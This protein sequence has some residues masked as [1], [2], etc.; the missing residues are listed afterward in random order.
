MVYPMRDQ[1]A[2]R[3]CKLLCCEIIP[4]FR[5]P[6][7][8]LS[9]RGANLLLHL[10][11][12]VCALLGTKKLNT[13][14]YHPMCN[15][16]VERFNRMLKNLLKKH[17]ARFV[18]NWDRYLDGVLW[19]YRNAPHESTGEK[20]SFLLFGVDLRTPNSK[21]EAALLPPTP[22]QP[23]TAEDYREEL[24]TNLSSARELACK[25]LCKVQNKSKEWY[26]KHKAVSRPLRV[27]D[28]VLVR[29]PVEESGKNRKLAHPWYGPYRII[30]LRDPD[31]TVV[32]VYKNPDKQIH[33]HLSRVTP[34]PDGITPGYYW[35]GERR[36]Q[37][38]RPPKWMNKLVPAD[39]Q[40]QNDDDAESTSKESRTDSVVGKN[41][42]SLRSHQTTGTQSRTRTM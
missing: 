21:I 17:A 35:Y 34:W 15:G 20:L 3:I 19:A 28:W 31:V 4:F 42:Y 33:V 11:S 16:M 7:A 36:N 29:F 2:G 27:G 38:G 18:P 1:T 23:C 39:D 37:P 12:D 26:D 14:S 24:I 30:S 9:D 25:S 32:Q 40:T 5:V 22:I 6:E 13:T 8:L 10:M 41:R